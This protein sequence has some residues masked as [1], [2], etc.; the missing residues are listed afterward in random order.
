MSDFKYSYKISLNS[1]RIIKK[2]IYI[3][4]ENI[5]LFNFILCTII[6]LRK[7]L[8]NKENNIFEFF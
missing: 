1:W 8:I 7:L 4:C 6:N 3:M 5:L 2:I